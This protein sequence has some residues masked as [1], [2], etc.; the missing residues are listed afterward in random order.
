VR[1]GVSQYDDS[2]SQLLRGHYQLRS[3]GG[4]PLWAE[5]GTPG[6][7]QARKL[8]ELSTA[9]DQYLRSRRKVCLITCG[10]A[11]S[12]TFLCAMTSRMAAGGSGHAS[13]KLPVAPPQLVVTTT[14]DEALDA[15]SPS[16]TWVASSDVAAQ[17]LTL[18]TL[19]AVISCFSSFLF[20]W[21]ISV[22]K[23][24]T[25]SMFVMLVPL[26][27]LIIVETSKELNWNDK[28][29]YP[30]IIMIT[31]GAS[32]GMFLPSIMSVVS[33]H[34]PNTK[35]WLTLGLPLGKL[36]VEMLFVVADGTTSNYGILPV[37]ITAGVVILLI[38]FGMCIHLF[39]IPHVHVDHNGDS[40]RAVCA[41][42]WDW[43][44]WV[45]F[46]LVMGCFASFVSTAC[47]SMFSVGAVSMALEKHTTVSLFGG[48]MD[49]EW[50]VP[51]GLV[52]GVYA[53]FGLIGG[54]MGRKMAYM[55]EDRGDGSN[56]ASTHSTC[57]D[58]FAR[59]PITFVA[60]TLVGGGVIASAF[61]IQWGVLLPVG[62]FLLGYGYGFVLNMMVRY[63]DCSVPREANL[64]AYVLL[65]GSSFGGSCLVWAMPVWMHVATWMGGD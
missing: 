64:S 19:A 6:T 62:V 57:A 39:G 46:H 53:V 27:T 45:R 41:V 15:L 31:S 30:E 9:F 51:Q 5:K 2:S 21:W 58:C 1:H 10:M 8:R 28:N 17:Y 14:D 23:R 61:K 3:S 54:V 44:M 33:P 59:T 12:F 25:I 55:V 26:I 29:G 56:R 47:I 65:L 50:I 63:I 22:R 13:G 49:S 40:A 4:H 38:V 60:V 42:L 52:M 7:N 48:G 35:L 37:T 34:G 36:V 16:S 20:F 32:F 24:V 11:A 18:G 43:K